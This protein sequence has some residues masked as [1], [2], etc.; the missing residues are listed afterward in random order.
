LTIIAAQK[1][2]KA[3]T[4][5]SNSYVL[6]STLPS[7]YR[8]P[9]ILLPPAAPSVEQESHY[10]GLYTFVVSLIYF[11]GGSLSEAK[12]MRYLRRGNAETNT[13]IDSTDKV[14]QR[15]IKDGYIN[16]VKD[17]STGEELV[18]FYVGPRGKVEIG[19]EGSSEFAKMVWGEEG[20]EDLQARLEKTFALQSKAEEAPG[21]APQ[22]TRGR[23]KRRNE[24]QVEEN[25]ADEEESD[26]ENN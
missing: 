5:S 3:S 25:G 17:N 11:S 21:P 19:P 13:P 7:K 23:P 10:T 8:T 2:E 18:D 15:M 26:V 20:Q 1:N 16:R 22:R 14:L 4:T 12:L 24:G 6:T 9:E